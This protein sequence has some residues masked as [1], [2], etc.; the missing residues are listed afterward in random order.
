[1][2]ILV[3]TEHIEFPHTDNKV[4]C[5]QGYECYVDGRKVDI[6]NISI[7]SYRIE[8]KDEECKVILSTY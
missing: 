6:E 4:G 1:M 7:D 5:E 2:S 3:E 8:I